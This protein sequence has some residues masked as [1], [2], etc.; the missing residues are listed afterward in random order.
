MTIEIPRRKF[1]LGLIGLIAAPA[2]VRAASLM[3]VK[4]LPLPTPNTAY[5]VFNRAIIVS[6]DPLRLADFPSIVEAINR[7]APGSTIH[8]LP[9]HIET[10]AEGGLNFGARDVRMRDTIIG[11]GNLGDRPAITTEGK[12]TMFNNYLAGYPVT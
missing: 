1:L 12:V 3:P 9:G 7:S 8:V 6:S 2:V 11:F 10:V 4:A 5:E